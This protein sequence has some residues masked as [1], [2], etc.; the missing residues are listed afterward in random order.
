MEIK[1]LIGLSLVSALILLSGCDEEKSQP[2]E[3]DKTT[4]TV[5]KSTHVKAPVEESKA[6]T[7]TLTK[8]EV[9]PKTQTA[10]SEEKGGDSTKGMK[11]YGKKIKDECG[12]NG[13]VFA[14]KHTQS[15]WIKIKDEGKMSDEI[16]SI[17]KGMKIRDKYIKDLSAFVIEYAS[18][19]GNVPSC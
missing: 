10:K 11:I 5:E 6:D 14:G 1:K 2:K 17:C 8:S 16:S 3:K 19:S 12:I 18:D 7:P 9:T 15:E 13:V 4:T